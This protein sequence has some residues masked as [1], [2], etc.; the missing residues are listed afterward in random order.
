M[1][2]SLPILV[3]IWGLLCLAPL[4]AQAALVEENS[5]SFGTNSLVLDTQ[6]GLT[7]LDL[8]F[9]T[10]LS[11]QQ[12]LSSLQAGGTFNGFRYATEQEVLGLFNSA[13]ISG[14]GNYSVTNSSVTSFISLIGDTETLNGYPGIFGISGTPGTAAPSQMAVA[15]QAL[16]P[17]GLTSYVY[18]FSVTSSYGDGNPGFPTVGSWLVEVPEPGS[19]LLLLAGIAGL[20]LNGV[21]KRAILRNK[22]CA[23]APSGAASL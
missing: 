16:K 14:L 6:S 19:H 4:S 2:I 10:G 11:Y 8:P 17:D 5:S 7:W 13:G 21:R 1:K 18:V 20:A 23:T 3:P 22:A 9:T 15:M 12:M